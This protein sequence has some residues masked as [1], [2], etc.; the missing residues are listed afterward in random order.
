MIDSASGKLHHILVLWTR[1]LRPPRLRKE[2]RG[3]HMVGSANNALTIVY[4]EYD[5]RFLSQREPT[6]F[7]SANAISHWLKDLEVLVPLILCYLSYIILLDCQ[8]M[9]LA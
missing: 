6:S 9:I 8:K 5:V 2:V 4:L 1:S 7:E 3:T